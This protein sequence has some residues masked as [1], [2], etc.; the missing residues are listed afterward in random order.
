MSPRAR[1]ATKP[2]ITIGADPEFFLS[3]TSGTHY[4]KS[5]IGLI[6]GTKQQPKSL[7]R[8]GYFVQED[9]VAVEFNIPPATNVDDF[10]NSIQW[11]MK[12]IGD[13][14]NKFGLQPKISA[15]EIFP[16]PELAHPLA[17]MFGC[18]PDYNAWQNGMRN[19]KPMDAH[20]RLRSCGGH[21][22]AAIN[23]KVDVHSMIWA[24][25]L[26]LGVPSVMMDEDTSRRFLYGRAGSYRPTSYDTT[27][28][29]YRVLSNFW[30]RSPELSKWAYEQTMRAIQFVLGQSLED[31]VRFFMKDKLSEQIVHC[32]NR[33]DVDLSHRLIQTYDLAVS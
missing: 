11:S 31:T 28:W 8:D 21:I 5:A 10:V 2:T 25:D 32:I 1:E 33:S 7:G 20:K 22:H 18:D 17:Q 9:N 30:I 6:G 29:E 26:F 15:A 3:S 24:K 12:T 14:V 16:E 23:R 4:L 13:R 19:M 27:S